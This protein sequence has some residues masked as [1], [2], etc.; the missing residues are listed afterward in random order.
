MEE[1]T[2]PEK[3]ENVTLND[4][5]KIATQNGTYSHTYKKKMHRILQTGRK[6][7]IN[8]QKAALALLVTIFTFDQVL[9]T[10]HHLPSQQP[11]HQPCLH[12]TEQPHQLTAVCE[13]CG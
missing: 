8:G 3:L 1:N 4:P 11:H 13:V 5:Y 9:G 2:K 7:I 10:Q 12:L 6:W